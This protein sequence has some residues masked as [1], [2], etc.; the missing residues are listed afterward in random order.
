LNGKIIFVDSATMKPVI[1]KEF[2]DAFVF[3]EGFA[4]VK[5][6]G[7][8]GYIDEKSKQLTDFKYEDGD[9]FKNGIARVYFDKKASFIFVDSCVQILN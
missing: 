1:E 8:Y 2:D 7:K 3:A 4:F 9:N 5:L 6:N